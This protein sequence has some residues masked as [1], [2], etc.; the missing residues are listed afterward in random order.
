MIER[1]TEKAVQGGKHIGRVLR[2]E[3]VEYYFGITGGHVFPIQ[4]GLG[5]AGIKLL[6]MR[7]E[8]AGAYAADG[9][10]RASGKVGVCIGT[11]GPGMTNTIS[12]IAHAQA[13]K[14]PVVAIYGQHNTWEDGRPAEHESYAVQVVGPFTKW[15]RR[16]ISPYTIAF[17]VKKAVRDALTYPQAPVAL[18]LPLDI[19]T[20]K[21]TLSQQQ[22]WVPDA[23]KE[24]GPPEANTASVEAAVKMLLTAERPVIAGGEA[25][26]WVDA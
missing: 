24:P 4:V 15:T 5:M 20:V 26:F 18:E 8:Q 23:Y 14:S 9:Y 17:F 25:G 10:A 12:G 19:Q 21:T 13:C 7:H 16:I 6:H 11:A 2:E 22:G 3:G 1:A